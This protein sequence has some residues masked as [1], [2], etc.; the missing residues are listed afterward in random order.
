LEFYADGNE[1]LD[2]MT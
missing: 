2:S 1:P